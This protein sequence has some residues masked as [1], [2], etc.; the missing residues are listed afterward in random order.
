MQCLMDGGYSLKNH[1]VDQE[2]VITVITV[3]LN[4]ENH[5]ERCIQSVLNQSFKQIEHVIIDG[6]SIDGTIN[7]LKQFNDQIAYWRSEPDQGVY[8]AMN[9]GL[10]YARGKWLLFLGADDVLLDGFSEMASLL[11]EENCIYYGDVL[12]KNQRLGSKYTSYKLAKHNICHQAVFYPRTVFNKMKFMERYRISADH[13]LNIQCWVDHDFKWQYLPKL[14]TDFSDEGMSSLY[15]DLNFES[16]RVKIIKD[17][18]GPVVYIRYLFRSLKFK[19][20]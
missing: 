7:I 8:N 4:A 20:K 6:K 17:Y 11:H 19:L 2:P 16:D 14:I 18:L 1:K 13:L 5:I 9:K 3:C 12:Y 10:K 15:K